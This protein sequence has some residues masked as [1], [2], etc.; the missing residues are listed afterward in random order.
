MTIWSTF[1][2]GFND[3]T[4][5]SPLWASRPPHLF[6]EAHEA[7]MLHLTAASSS[8]IAALRLSIELAVYDGLHS[9]ALDFIEVNGS[10]PWEWKMNMH[11]E[12]FP[13]ESFCNGKGSPGDSKNMPS[14]ISSECSQLPPTT[15]Q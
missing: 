9:R 8:M 11:Y 3:Q 2:G 14:P 15:A 7:G 12:S 13:Q 1:L 6:L 4:Q 5:H 10:Y